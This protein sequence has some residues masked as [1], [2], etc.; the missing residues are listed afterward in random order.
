VIFFPR[1]KATV[2]YP[3]AYLEGWKDFVRPLAKGLKEIIEKTEECSEVFSWNNS[4]ST[5]VVHWNCLENFGKILMC[6]PL[7]QENNIKTFA[8]GVAQAEL[9]LDSCSD[10]FNGLPRLKTIVLESTSYSF[11]SLKNFWGLLG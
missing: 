3:L 1:R 5:L 6:G 11:W 2:K 8:D 9:F 4:L 7:T 10:G